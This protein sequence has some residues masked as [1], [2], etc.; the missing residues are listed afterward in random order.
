MS[1]AT[2]TRAVFVIGLLALPLSSGCDRTHLS[3]AYGQ[4]QRRAFRAQIVN[5]DASKSA[6]PVEGLDPEEAAIVADTYRKS[7]S[8]KSD[9][10]AA[11]KAPVLILQPNQGTG[12]SPAPTP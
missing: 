1:T 2:I 5:P 11:S 12:T 3:R 9:D 6:K 10:R 8:P 4:A 7:M